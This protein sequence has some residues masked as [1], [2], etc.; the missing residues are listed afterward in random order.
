MSILRSDLLFPPFGIEG[1]QGKLGPN[2]RLMSLRPQSVA[3]L[4]Y[5]VEHTGR[6][7]SKQ[8]ILRACWPHIQVSPAALK[9]CISE[10]RKALGDNALAPQLIETVPRQGYRFIGTVV[11]SA[12]EARG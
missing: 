12:K 10:I 9:V 8:E 3:V 4:R 7:V 5:L 1:L 2:E 6:I 11:S